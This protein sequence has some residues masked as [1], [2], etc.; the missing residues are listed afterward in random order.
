MRYL[1]ADVLVLC[2]APS[3]LAHLRDFVGTYLNSEYEIIHNSVVVK[4][5]K[6]Y[7]EQQI[8]ALVRKDL[9]IIRR[10]EALDENSITTLNQMYPYPSSSSLELEGKVMRVYWSRFPIEFD[11]ALKSDPEHW[12]KVI[13]TYPKSKA[14]KGH[15]DAIRARWKNFEQ[16]RV[17]RSR[18]E[19]VHETFEDILILGDMNDSEGMDPVEKELGIDSIKALFQGEDDPILWNPIKF[20]RGE[21]TYIYK[22]IPE[23]IDYIFLTHGLK[24]GKGWAS[25]KNY[26]HFHFFKTMVRQT[27]P[28]KPDRLEKRGLFLS[29]HAPVTLD[30]YHNQRK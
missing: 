9:F 7:Y 8:A 20:S 24:S 1:D 14:S 28:S 30:I 25:E 19:S 11:L 17:I 13:A 2:E 3:N 23:V 29:D 22:G 6:Y 15:S 16:Q 26:E 21:G 10:Y 12:Y 18:I 27:L 5:K 4:D